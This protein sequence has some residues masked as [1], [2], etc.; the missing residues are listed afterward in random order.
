[1]Q[2]LAVRLWCPIDQNALDCKIESEWFSVSQKR[3]HV[4]CW[5]MF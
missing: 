2:R 4:W 5:A 3:D 1:M